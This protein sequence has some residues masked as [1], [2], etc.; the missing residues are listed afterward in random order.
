MNLYYGE[1]TRMKV[2]SAFSEKFKVKVGV[3]QRSVLSPLLIA[4]VVNV[5]PEKARWGVVYELRYADDLVVM[6]ETMEDLKES[7]WNW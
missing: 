2:G 7:F 4:I 3:H 1:K 5:I 6:S